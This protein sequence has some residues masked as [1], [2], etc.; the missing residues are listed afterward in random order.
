MHSGQP[1]GPPESSPTR[2]SG[3]ALYVPCGDAPQGS[4]DPHGSTY[5][6]GSRASSRASGCS[7]DTCA[8][9]E[10]PP[11]GAPGLTRA[12]AWRL[13][14]RPGG[15]VNQPAKSQHSACPPPGSGRF[16]RAAGHSA[17]SGRRFSDM[18]SA[19]SLIHHHDE[20]IGAKS[21]DTVENP[22][23]KH[24]TAVDNTSRTIVDSWCSLL[25][26]GALSYSCL[27]HQFLE[28]LLVSAVYAAYFPQ[29][30]SLSDNGYPQSCQ[31]FCGVGP[32]K[33]CVVALSDKLPTGTAAPESANC[34]RHPHKL[35][36][37]WVFDGFHGK[38]V[39]SCGKHCG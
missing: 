24:V 20:K 15:S 29:Y 27:A 5:A 14:P 25:E 28:K 12:Q 16:P 33:G 6:Y 9:L 21:V 19:C 4:H 17:G 18:L 32:I 30:D 13:Y 22:G 26:S 38:I 31:P 1:F 8:S 37:R 34:P 11:F 39:H 10:V 23:H 2:R 3:R 7:A 36:V 35:R